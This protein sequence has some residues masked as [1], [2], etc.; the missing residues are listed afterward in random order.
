MKILALNP[1][2]LKGYTRQSRSPSVAQGGTFYYPYYLAYAVGTLEAAGF[3]VILLD[4][5]A[6]K[7]GSQ[8]VLDFADTLRPDLVIVFTS[9]PSIYND[10]DIG[11]KI[12]RIL[13][14][15]HLSF[16]GNHPTNMPDEVMAMSKDIDSICRWEIDYTV[17]ELAEAIE[18]QTKFDE[19]HGLTYRENGEVFHNPDRER[20]TNLDELPF[21][22]KVYKEQK[23]V[24]IKDYFYAQD[25][26]PLVVILTAR[27]CP[28]N[29]S[30]C[31]IPFKKSYRARS[32]DN[33]IKEFEYI[34]QELPEVREVMIEDDTFPIYKERTMEFCDRLIQEG[35]ELKWACN[36][37][38]DTDKEVLKKMKEAGCRLLCVGFETPSQNLLKEIKK[39]T[40]KER[41]IEFMNDTKE[42]NILVNGCFLIGVLNE[43]RE[44]IERT[45]EFAKVL[46]P[47][48]AQFLPLMVYP[49]TEA[50]EV[51]KEKGVLMGD[52]NDLLDNNGYHMTNIK[53]EKLS[54]QDVKELRDKAYREY[55]L[56]AAYIFY[57][58]KQSITNPTEGFRI[59]KGGL[60]FLKY[61]YLYKT[62]R[63]HKIHT[64]E[65]R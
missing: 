25:L 16:V 45:I 27:G 19:I 33:V 8:K 42:L 20:I 10:V 7:W 35:I 51:A 15:A 62:T 29:C 12:K 36:A 63:L 59:L 61:L 44:S 26:Y 52:Y 50:F 47:D 55:Y 23:Y 54:P 4:A 5:V 28:W 60:F 64:D 18:N 46:N 56:R 48:T 40:T 58:L 43:D 14:D 65:R 2:F 49:G 34:K 22:S 17:V 57:K 3:D 11:S 32:V 37:R 9:T 53:T 1:P 39:K 24:D 30:F 38:V 21:V 13:P 31:D 41:Q 6:K